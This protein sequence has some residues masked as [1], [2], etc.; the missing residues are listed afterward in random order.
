M[1]QRA[2]NERGKIRVNVKRICK[3]TAHAG[4]SDTVFIHGDR[5]MLDIG[6]V[7][8][9]LSGL[10]KISNLLLNLSVIVVLAHAVSFLL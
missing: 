2:T 6:V 4:N 9:K 7:L 3:L 10:L 1:K 5:T 8:R